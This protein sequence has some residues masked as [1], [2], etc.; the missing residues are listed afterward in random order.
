M[1]RHGHVWP[2][3]LAAAV[4]AVA[5]AGVLPARAAG[6]GEAPFTFAAWMKTD[7]HHV[8][9]FSTSS[10]EPA[11]RPGWKD[12]H[13]WGDELWF[14][15]NDSGSFCARGPLTDNRWHHVAFV[16]DPAAKK[17]IIYLDG[18]PAATAG[19]AMKPDAAGAA[20]RIG[21][22]V[23]DAGHALYTFLGQMDDVR[24][25]GR[26]LS[27]DEIRTVQAGG[28]VSDGGAYA[29]RLKMDGD[30]DEVA[31]LG[32][33]DRLTFVEGKAGRAAVFNGFGYLEVAADGGVKFVPSS[34]RFD[35]SE[36]ERA[37]EREDG[38]S[39]PCD[40]AAAQAERY[41]AATARR[42]PALV[43]EAR[44]RAANVRDIR[45]LEH[46]R[47]TYLEACRWHDGQRARVRDVRTSLAATAQYLGELKQA[48]G[49]K[50]DA[51]PFERR[52]RELEQ[53]AAAL[54]AAPEVGDLVQWNADLDRLQQEVV[55]RWLVAQGIPR[56][57]FIKRFTY[58]ANHYYTE[59]VNSG[60][61]P[62]GNLCVLDLR[63]GTVKDL[64]PAEMGGGVFERF[65]V[66][67]DAKKIVFAW[68]PGPREGYRIYEIG[69]DGAGLRQLT[70]P[71]ADEADLVR[72]YGRGYHHGTD[73][74]SPCYLPDGG[75]AF[76]ST[77]CQY[78]T[79]CDSP[80]D[81]TTTVLFRMDADG[82]NL[83]QLS[84]SALSEQTPVMLE[85]GRLLYSRWEY[86]DKGAVSVKCLW[87]MRPDGTG[88][89]EV[90]GN[91]I[92]LPPT[93]TQGRGIPGEPDGYV[94]VGTPH[95]PQNGV[96][97]V[98]RLDMRK[99]IRSREPMTYLTPYTDIRGEGGFEFQRPDGSWYGDGWGRGP[100]FR[101][102]YP[103]SKTQVL[104]AHK[105]EGAVHIAPKAYG[106]YL[107]AEG[108]AVQPVYRDPEISCW[109]PF[110]LV[111][112]RAPPV[113]TSARDEKLAQAGQARCV[114]TDV[115]HG[116][117]DVERG[118]IKYIRVLEQRPRPWTARRYYDGDE[119]DQQHAVVSK[120]T[121]LGLKVQHG[122]VPV[123]ADGSANFLV[124]ANA[125]IF[126]QV[127]DANHM[128]V[129]TER[130]FVNYM[131][132]EVR[133]CIGCHETPQSAAQMGRTPGTPQAL[134]RPPSVPGPQPGEKDGRRPLDYALD[135]QPVWN[136]HCL[137]C[138]SGGKPE[139][140]LDLSGTPTEFFSVSYEQLVPQRRRGQFDRGL[141]GPV[142]GE[143]HPKTGNVEYLPA[144][145]LGSHAS[146]LVTMLSHGRVMPVDPKQAERARKLIE[147]HKDVKLTAAELVRVTNWVDTNAQFYGSY[148][149]RRN[150]RYR[151]LPDFRPAPTFEQAVSTVN[152]YPVERR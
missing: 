78:G 147:V 149:G 136:R 67:F 19:H 63:D 89:A 91:T 130:T 77:R 30:A 32:C 2:G 110:P 20:L 83:R 123:E 5:G 59:Y 86:V 94:L 38:V 119:Y 132:G 112:R 125:S 115:Y 75:I 9:L 148:W 116:L 15:G 48:E 108:G 141:L 88:S 52:A 27:A 4:L 97:T 101:D 3:V 81:F 92:A 8:V 42:N 51:A 144:K 76:V 7:Q 70:F 137:D 100:L 145:S 109:V 40:G 57:A 118:A 117:Q 22:G 74:M 60:W 85:D 47:E 25:H 56:L 128:A 17:Q 1:R 131:P 143:N 139:G 39:A 134:R 142:I 46:L 113:L 6:V 31:R 61:M 140:K 103:L 80:D 54:G 73:D 62:G 120:D 111:P 151:D 35:G 90:Y 43:D 135:V 50:F 104:V 152:P 68:K 126:L 55:R 107:L 99:N 66:S 37:W 138:H 64:L 122:I 102:P 33:G 23:E 28:E 58:N 121:A 53:R 21:R 82:K 133:S 95:F 65:D 41:V 36:T 106:L 98:I 29:V 24:V 13:T 84:T 79:L 96:G 87:A 114:V 71:Q 49:A 93:M 69:A 26:A 18:Q 127:L 150:L 45:G 72:R 10:P 12:L 146:V 14:S 129:Q 11:G 124:P 44:R 16:S 34:F 105:P